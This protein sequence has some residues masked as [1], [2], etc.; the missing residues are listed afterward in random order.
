MDEGTG[1]L[2]TVPSPPTATTMS[3]WLSLASAASSEAA[4]WSFSH[5]YLV[6]ELLLVQSRIYQTGNRRFAAG[7]RNR[8]HDEN[9][10]FF[11]ILVKKLYF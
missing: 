11:H 1:Y 10:L 3:A 7:S 9:Y 8:V 6:L 5:F 4:S 2:F